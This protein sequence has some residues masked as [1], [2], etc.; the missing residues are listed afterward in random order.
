[1][2]VCFAKHHSITDNFHQLCSMLRHK[3]VLLAGLGFFVDVFDMFLFSVLRKPS[4]ENIGITPERM[5]EV[6]ERLLSIQMLGMLIGGFFWGIL[7]DRK[8]RLSVLVGSILLY[9]SATLANAFVH[10][11]TTYGICR[12]FAGLGLA[13]E[14]GAGISLVLEQLDE[15]KRGYGT[16]LVAALGALG[17]VVA[18]LTAGFFTWQQ[19]Y[20]GGGLMGFAL[21]L[22]RF[23]VGESSIFKNSA[24]LSHRGNPLVLLQ[25]GRWKHYLGCTLAGVPI[26]FSVGMCVSFLPELGKENGIEGLSVG[27]AMIWFQSAFCAGDVGSG[28]ISQRIQS[29][30]KVLLGFLVSLIPSLILFFSVLKFQAAPVWVY[31][32]TGLLG[33]CC[34]YMAV[35][36]TSVAE[37]FG[38]DL[39]ATVTGSVVNLMR[40]SVVL[41]VPIHAWLTKGFHLGL[42]PSLAIIGSVVWTLAIFGWRSFRETYGK[43][44]D[45]LE[46]S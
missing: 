38:T 29:R 41:L 1:M 44:L 24:H 42:I 9:S 30:K 34:G 23:G 11:E 10:D 7:G 3:A 12:F 14:L 13:G 28:W 45:F 19:A 39:R 22:L 31:A 8:G 21:L 32:A 20:I 2:L 26:W 27:T 33:W 6:G 43:S 40:G 18:A 4:L 36:V 15:K 35:F 5:V 17:A 46:K 16:L 25:N 37:Q